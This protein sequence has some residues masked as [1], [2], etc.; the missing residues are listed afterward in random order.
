MLLSLTFN[1]IPIFRLSKASPVDSDYDE[2]NYDDYNYD[3]NSQN[4]SDDFEVTSE[5]SQLEATKSDQSVPNIT[6]EEIPLRFDGVES[7]QRVSI[8]QTG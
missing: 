7:V 5:T 8:E 3:D 6:E 2:Y 4:P 1:Y